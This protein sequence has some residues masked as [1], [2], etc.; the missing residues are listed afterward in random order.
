MKR[1]LYLTQISPSLGDNLFFPYS[2]GSIYAYCAAIKEIDDAYAMGKFFFRRDPIDAVLDRLERPDI[3]GLS[4]YVWNWSYNMALAK[5]VRQRY[6]DCLIVLGG[7]NVPDRSEDFFLDHP[8]VDLLVHGEG[9][10]AFA[11]IMRRRLRARE[12]T[13]YIPVQG[14]S[15]RLADGACLRTEAPAK[16]PDLAA[17]PSP[18]LSGVFDRLLDFPHTYVACQ[19]THRGCPY[20]CSF[21]DWGSN[22][23]SKVRTF[24]LQRVLDEIEWFARHKIEYIQNCDANFGIFKR[25]MV[26]TEKIKAVHEEYGWPKRFHASYAKNSN[27]NI[28]NIGKVLLEA[29]SIKAILISFQ[30]LNEETLLSVKRKNIPLSKLT[31]LLDQCAEV[32]LKTATEMVLG[33]PSEAYDSFADGLD[34]LLCAGQHDLIAVYP[35]MVLKNSEMSQPDYI[36]AHGIETLRLPLNMPYSTPFRDGSDVTEYQDIIIQTKDMPRADWKRTYIFAVAVQT[37]HCFGLLKFIAKY[38]YRRFGVSYRTF[39]E[40]V[41][42]E[43]QSPGNKIIHHELARLDSRICKIMAGGSN[44]AVLP[45]YGKVIWPL[46]QALFLALVADKA[47]LYAEIEAWL[48][49]L[50]ARLSIELEEG[51]MHDLV[52]FQ[53]NMVVDAF[54][55]IQ[56]TFELDH[57]LPSYLTETVA[58]EDRANRKAVVMVQSP[59]AYGGDLELYAREVVWYGRQLGRSLKTVTQRA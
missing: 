4:C 8:Y 51:V 39:Y 36:A 20:S 44:G 6:P 35:C 37:L 31:A 48:P 14:L 56:S 19:E 32:G 33:L 42:I 7:P 55:E 9:E 38:L 15:I 52:L 57:Q 25:D 5:A 41:L 16:K 28:I 3:L 21:C 13:D 18:Y 53:R 12:L 59:A 22:T 24:D 26:I 10:L 11:D 47:A 34:S 29:G 17:F 49:S 46:E 2:V 1:N 54:D 50:C 23:F 45:E 30:S 40:T 27:E 43:A 58:W